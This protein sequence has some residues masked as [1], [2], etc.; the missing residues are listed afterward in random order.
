MRYLNLSSVIH[1][2]KKHLLAPSC[3]GP[4]DIVMKKV[5]SRPQY[6]TAEWGG[7]TGK[8]AITV[9]C[10]ASFIWVCPGCQGVT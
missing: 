4:G 7:Q 10:D 3:V 8:P 9:G 1:L 2:T 5:Q 6:R